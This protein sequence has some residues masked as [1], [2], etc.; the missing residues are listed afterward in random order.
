MRFLRKLISII[1]RTI[2]LT[3]FFLNNFPVSSIDKKIFICVWAAQ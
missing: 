3:F 2:F 1:I